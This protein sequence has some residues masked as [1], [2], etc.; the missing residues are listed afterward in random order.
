ML[1]AVM[2]EDNNS[3]V[4]KNENEQGIPIDERDECIGEN[5]SR[6]YDSR[7]IFNEKT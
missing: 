1:T 6:N 7:D 3:H 2:E 4:Q 5:I